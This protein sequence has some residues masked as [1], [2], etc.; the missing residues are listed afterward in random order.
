MLSRTMEKVSA[1]LGNIFVIVP[2][3]GLECRM[4]FFYVCIFSQIFGT[5]Y[6]LQS[7]DNLL[8]T[9]QVAILNL[10]ELVWESG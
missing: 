4:R 10:L 1:V 8:T 9:L 3:Q 6:G 7:N 2:S 5:S